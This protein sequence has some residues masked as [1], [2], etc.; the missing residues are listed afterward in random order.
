ML[1]ADAEGDP[2][3]KDII[4]LCVMP[5]ENIVEGSKLKGA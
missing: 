5:L 2:F 4:S 3:P 1:G